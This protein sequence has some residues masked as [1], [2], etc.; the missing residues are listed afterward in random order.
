MSNTSERIE[1]GGG[2]YFEDDI[3]WY[4]MNPDGTE[5]FPETNSWTLK[6]VK[7]FK[8]A[9]AGGVQQGEVRAIVEEDLAL[10]DDAVGEATYTLQGHMGPDAPEI[11]A[12]TLLKWNAGIAKLERALTPPNI[13]EAAEK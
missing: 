7:A 12:R 10:D 9:I 13:S 1:I 8:A 2:Y 3:G 6:Q 11:M 4:M 5:S